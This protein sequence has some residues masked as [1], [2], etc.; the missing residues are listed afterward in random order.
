MIHYF[1]AQ[2]NSLKNRLERIKQVVLRD[3]PELS[4]S[5]PSPDGIKIKKLGQHGLIMTD[6]C[7]TAQKARGLLWFEI[8]GLV[9][10]MD[11]HHHLCNVWIKGMEKSGSIFLR[12][13]LSDCLEQIP[14][15]LRFTCIF[16]AIACT[17]DKFFS[18]CANYPKSQGEHFAARLRM[19]KPGTPL[20]PCWSD[21]RVT[22]AP[23][24]G[25]P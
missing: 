8:G 3:Y 22:I 24:A 16:S 21:V 6:S 17:W 12:V 11:C 20:S 25:V 9:F 7:N 13:I 2:I 23:L 5:T 4:D 15:E 19:N 18:L 14:P 10:E 1:S